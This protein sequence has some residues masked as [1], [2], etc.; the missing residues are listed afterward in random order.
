MKIFAIQ[1]NIGVFPPKTAVL[2]HSNANLRPDY[3][4]SNSGHSQVAINCSLLS[5]DDIGAN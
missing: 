1:Q 4:S 3:D 2:S 5:P